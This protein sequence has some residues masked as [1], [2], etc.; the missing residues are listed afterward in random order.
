MTLNPATHLVV[1][2]VYPG[3]TTLDVTGP[4]QV[5]SEVGKVADFTAPPYAVI[6]GSRRGGPIESDSGIVFQTVAL[7][8]LP[9]PVD[10]VVVSGGLGVFAAAEDRELLRWV[11]TR[12]ETARRTAST[13]MGAFVTAAAGLLS[14]KKAVTHWRWCDALRRRHPEVTVVPDRLFLQDG[15]VWSSAGVTAGI[16]LALAMVEADLGREIALAV[17]RSLVVLP[18]RPGGQAPYG[19]NSGMPTLESDSRFQGLHAWLREHLQEDLRVERLA[20]I[21]AMSPRTFARTYTLVMKTTPARAVEALRVDAARHSLETSQLPL[22]AIA[23]D[24]GFRSVDRLRRAF[25]R[26]FG[27]LPNDYRNYFGTDRIGDR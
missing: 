5:F 19:P 23:H 9:G 25:L 21:A 13:C 26:N 2:V 7:D 16:N 12:A 1:F 22:K 4:A 10:T 8:D 11:A 27:M 15:P 24:C 20:E 3:V 6:L 14:G 17:A 18:K